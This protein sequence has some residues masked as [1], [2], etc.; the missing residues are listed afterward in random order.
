VVR[1]LESRALKWY[2]H[3]DGIKEEKL[4][5]NGKH[6]VSSAEDGGLGEVRKQR[7]LWKLKTVKTTTG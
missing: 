3:A 4:R 5:M 7:L 2:G 6:I 1:N